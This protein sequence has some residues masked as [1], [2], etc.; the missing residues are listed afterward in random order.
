M[1]YGLRAS[2]AVNKTAALSPANLRAAKNAIGMLSTPIRAN[3]SLTVV[4]VTGKESP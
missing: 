1:W 3:G 2:S 4:S